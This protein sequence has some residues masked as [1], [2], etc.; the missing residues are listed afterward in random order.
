MAKKGKTVLGWGKTYLDLAHR[1]VTEAAQEADADEHEGQR[2]CAAIFLAAAALETTA[3]ELVFAFED[4]GEL[5]GKEAQSIRD[6][7]PPPERY[8]QLAQLILRR[9][10]EEVPSFGVVQFEKACMVWKCRKKLIH[11]IP[12]RAALGRW[13]DELLPYHEKNWLPALDSSHHWT[14][15]L[16]TTAVAESIVESTE[17]FLEWFHSVVAFPPLLASIHGYK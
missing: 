14:S 13:P 9:R 7:E 6:S 10:G 16:P 8:K 4:A 11:Y 5:P 3:Y 17:R 1:F 12:V 2:S 15:V